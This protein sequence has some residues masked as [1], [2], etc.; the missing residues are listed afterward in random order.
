MRNDLKIGILLG[1]GLIAVVMIYFVAFKPDGTGDEGDTGEPEVPDFGQAADSSDEGTNIIVVDTNPLPDD[2][3]SVVDDDDLIVVDD[4]FDIDSIYEPDTMPDGG[5][6]YDPYEPDGQADGGYS[7]LRG[8]YDG[9]VVEVDPVIEVDPVVPPAGT[10]VART[11]TV[12]AGDT[13]G[14]SG[15]AQ[16]QYGSARY[17]T[18]IAEA[19]PGIRTDQLRP[20]MQLVLPPLPAEATTPSEP[21][22][23]LRAGER[24]YTVTADDT[25][26]F[27]DIAQAMYDGQGRYW[28]L[29]AEANP[30]VDSGRLVPGMQLVIPPLPQPEFEAV[31]TPNV[32][33]EPG[34]RTYTVTTSDTGGYW[35]VAQNVYGQGSLFYVIEQANPDV[36]STE[37]RAGM[38]LIIPP[39]P[40]TSTPPSSGGSSQETYVPAE[41]PAGRPRFD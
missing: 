1:I 35:S 14:F 11:Y 30:G 28:T 16:D 36:A 34:Y 8:G 17:W 12:T 22:R 13:G 39:R 7:G 3:G 10:G 4:S 18:L 24:L 41:V 27:W 40:A 37:L 5:S 38:V 21:E 29:I 15:I 25:G 33:L 6:A 31:S 32:Q 26:G 2:D 19:N 20:G 9:P 23:E